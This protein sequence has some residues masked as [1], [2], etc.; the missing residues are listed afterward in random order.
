MINLQESDSPLDELKI[1]LPE[2]FSQKAEEIY[3]VV[4]KINETHNLT[5]ITSPED[6]KIRHLID[7]I[8]SVAYYP[9]LATE[10]LKIL[11]LG[12]GGGFPCIPLSAYNPKLN[13][14]GLD[15]EG[16]KVK[17]V[18]QAASELGLSNLKTI[19]A[20]GRE[21]A[22]KEEHK[23]QYDIVTARAVAT[24]DKLIKECRQFL[25]PKGRILLYKTPEAIKK[26]EKLTLRE[27][28]KYKFDIELSPIFTLP[29]DAGQRQFIVF[30][31][32]R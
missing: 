1:Q 8:C 21:L 23:A 27:A 10:S 2:G 9:E 7:S 29:N 6:F 26:E 22:I 16:T 3:Q 19:H 15:S 24:A 20:R 14:T 17:C 25:K 4:T 11:D 5:R 32:Q 13:I 28:K 31:S 18:A 30:H 12:C